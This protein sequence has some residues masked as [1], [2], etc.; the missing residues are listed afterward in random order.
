MKL[1]NLI[2]QSAIVFSVMISMLLSG[3]TWKALDVYEEPVLLYNNVEFGEGDGNGRDLSAYWDVSESEKRI[4]RKVYYGEKKE[5]QKTPNNSAY[6]FVDEDLSM[7]LEFD[8]D[9]M[10]DYYLYVDTSYKLPDYR[11][12][13]T[14]SR[15]IIESGSNTLEIT[16]TNE[17]D[18]FGRDFIE[19]TADEKP[20]FVVDEAVEYY[21]IY[22]YYQDCKAR[23]YYG[24]YSITEN[25][26]IYFSC[27]DVDSEKLYKS[28]QSVNSILKEKGLI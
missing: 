4:L 23:Y 21:P 22:F 11:Q 28:S 14:I 24:L 20:S 26:T 8:P 6:G 25:G 13:A 15:I 18:L 3:C 12:G 2:L 1:F 9:K 10:G 27:N 5:N 19:A 17:L 16:E 7:F